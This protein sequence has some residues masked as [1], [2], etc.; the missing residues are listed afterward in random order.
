MS[1]EEDYEFAYI[2]YISLQLIEI[3]KLTTAGWSNS[4]SM[5]G[6]WGLSNCRC[7]YKHVQRIFQTYSDIT[8]YGT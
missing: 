1:W 8:I 2:S 7:G 3:V 6:L 5:M 4:I